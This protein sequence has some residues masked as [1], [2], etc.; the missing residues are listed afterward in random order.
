MKSECSCDLHLHQQDAKA[1]E[2]EI[3][4]VQ[5]LEVSECFLPVE[6]EASRLH[7]T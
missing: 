7:S 5:K 6:A 2:C 1:I 3:S 4:E